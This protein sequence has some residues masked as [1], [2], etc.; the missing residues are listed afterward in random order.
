MS[1]IAFVWQKEEDFRTSNGDFDLKVISP[2]YL[3][4]VDARAFAQ[5]TIEFSK[6]SKH[7]I[8]YFTRNPY[9]IDQFDCDNVIVMI[10]CEKFRLSD[11]PKWE[12]C[13]GVFSSGEFFASLERDEPFKNA[14]AIKSEWIQ[15][16]PASFSDQKLYHSFNGLS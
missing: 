11:H 10:D 7:R 8:A 2:D 15:L 5:Q 6:K 16:D 1:C 4:P 12:Q 3:H 14:E 9:V 13:K